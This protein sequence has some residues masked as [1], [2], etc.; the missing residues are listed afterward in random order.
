MAGALVGTLGFKAFQSVGAIDPNANMYDWF[1]A[2]HGRIGAAITAG[3]ANNWNHWQ[4]GDQA[5]AASAALFRKMRGGAATPV[6][7][8]VQKA[9]GAFPGT[10]A[11]VWNHAQGIPTV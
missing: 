7:D 3:D 6:T 2:R 9:I 4:I 5:E 8:T 1:E 11:D 10:V